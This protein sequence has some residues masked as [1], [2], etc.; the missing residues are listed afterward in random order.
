[1]TILPLHNN[2]CLTD[3]DNMPC[4]SDDDD[5]PLCCLSTL[6]T[7]E[8]DPANTKQSME[9]GTIPHIT[10]HPRATLRRETSLKT[11]PLQPPIPPTM[12]RPSCYFT[13]RAHC[14]KYPFNHCAS[15]HGMNFI[16]NMGVSS[17][18]FS[19]NPSR[20][21]HGTSMTTCNTMMTTQ[22]AM[23]DHP[24]T[25]RTTITQPQTP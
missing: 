25:W 16:M 10:E 2:D 21:T 6:I 17:R 3:S 22:S 14:Q 8:N 4:I 24:R 18:P 1:M 12:T 9:Q 15:L 20:Q 7:E 19:W 13:A 5:Q 11:I 23:I